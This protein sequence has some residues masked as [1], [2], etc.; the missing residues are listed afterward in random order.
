[1]TW[2]APQTKADGSA[3]TDLVGFRIYYGI[4]RGN[5]SQS[6]L[7]SS[8]STLTYSIPNLSTG[9][10]YMVVTALDAS[11]NESPPSAEISKI[12]Q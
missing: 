1:M 2:A 3:S 5:Y 12:V 7:V 9:T 6:V 8:P 4:A 10:Y 11:N